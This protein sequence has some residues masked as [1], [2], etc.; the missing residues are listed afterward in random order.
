ML[1]CDTFVPFTNIKK[2]SAKVVCVSLHSSIV[3]PK[4][5]E[6]LGLC[7]GSGIVSIV[8]S[9]DGPSV[10]SGVGSGVGKGEG[11][12]LVGS[13]VGSGVGKGEGSWLGSGVG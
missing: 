3:G 13:G 4:V 11:S 6:S 1:T 5:G 8:D 12:W 9:N 7:E 10:D 2:V